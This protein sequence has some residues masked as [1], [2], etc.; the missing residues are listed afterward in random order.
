MRGR[1]EG[2]GLCCFLLHAARRQPLW[3]FLQ[4]TQLTCR[5]RGNSVTSWGLECTVSRGGTFVNYART[6]R[7]PL[8]GRTLHRHNLLLLFQIHSPQQRFARLF[9]AHRAFVAVWAPL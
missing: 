8:S 6:G 3:A 5:R 9:T 4:R 7:G 2:G 1:L